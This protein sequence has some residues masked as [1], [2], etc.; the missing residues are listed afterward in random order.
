M[1]PSIAND[2]VT[3]PVVGSVRTVMYSRPASLWRLTAPEVFAIC[4]SERI[5]SCILAPPETVQTTIG[6]RLSVAY[7]KARVIFSPVT[8]PMLPIMNSA[9]MTQRTVLMP[10]MV[11]TPQR[12]D[13][14]AFFLALT[15]FSS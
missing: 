15:S 11:H 13:S 14:F 8:V 12:T 1:S 9:S 6:S 3:P 7:S 4:M 2:A 10:S 5:P